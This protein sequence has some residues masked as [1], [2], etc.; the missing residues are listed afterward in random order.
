MQFSTVKQKQGIILA[1]LLFLSFL[2][3]VSANLNTYPS[4]K[5]NEEFNFTQVCSDATYI[6]LTNIRTPNGNIIINENM[7]SVGPGTFI[8]NYTG[9]SEGRHD[10]MGISDGCEKTFATWLDI[11]FT[12]NPPAD[13]FVIVLFS[14]SFLLV[15][16]Y[17][18]FLVINNIGHFAQLDYDLS[19]LMKNVGAYFVLVGLF[20]LEAQYLGNAL[21]NNILT[22][23]MWIGGFTNVA[24]SF[25]AFTFSH[26]NQVMKQKI[27]MEEY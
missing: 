19:D 17:M 12:G 2:S 11:T 27:K 9:T 20:F 21:I 13:G 7:T 1:A 8:Y 15:L 25:L 4:Q 18:S 3:I 26:L 6:T 10:F 22:W 24:L 5:L 23:L 16:F 14:I